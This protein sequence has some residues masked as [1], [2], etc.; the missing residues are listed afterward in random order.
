MLSLQARHVPSHPSLC[1]VDFQSP[2]DFTSSLA[3]TRAFAKGEIVAKIDRAVPSPKR[4]STVQISRDVH[5]ELN[6]DFVY[7]NHSCDPSVYIDTAR[8]I[9][10]AQKDI[11]EGGT[12]TFFYP[13]T[14]WDMGK[15]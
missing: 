6:S 4:Y 12:L 13:S 14:E 5:V 3:A 11:A 15:Q 10:V 8:M 7:M 2:K 1:W 9:I